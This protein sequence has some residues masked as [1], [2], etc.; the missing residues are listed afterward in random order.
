MKEAPLE[1]A[2]FRLAKWGYTYN[3]KYWDELNFAAGE[4]LWRIVAGRG[5]SMSQFALT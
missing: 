3:Q 4:Q 5:K 2:R 1:G